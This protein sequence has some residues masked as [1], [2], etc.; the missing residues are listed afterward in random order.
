MKDVKVFGRGETRVG[1]REIAPD[2]YWLDHC[3]GGYAPKYLKI[4]YSNMASYPGAETGLKNRPI[5]NTLSSYLIVD[6]KTI[7]LDTMGPAQGGSIIKGIKHV[8]G[9]RPLDY[10]WISHVELNHAGTTPFLLQAFPKAKLIALKGGHH[11][12]VH[13]LENSERVGVGDV[14]DLGDHSIEIV[15]P[16]V[17]DHGLTQWAYERTSGLLCTVD[18]AANFHPMGEC[19]KFLDEIGE[20]SP[21]L[22]ADITIVLR[23]TFPWLAWTDAKQIVAAVDDLFDRDVKLFA[24]MHA[25]IVRTNIDKYAGILKQAMIDSAT[26]PF[27][28]AA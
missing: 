3:L 21:H 15:D 20:L 24:P 1:V 4:M 27:C 11:Y 9:D 19:F 7:L 26:L 10:I 23:Y 25:P 17:V 12:K 22:L 18:W 2:I 28:L 13:G 6:K 14:I 8:L 16:I 5:E